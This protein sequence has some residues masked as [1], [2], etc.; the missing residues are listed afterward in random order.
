[1]TC[2]FSTQKKQF[3]LEIHWI[4][5][6]LWKPY[7]SIV[8]PHSSYKAVGNSMFYISDSSSNYSSQ[9]VWSPHQVINLTTSRIK[10]KVI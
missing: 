2:K 7:R 10:Q 4:V 8:L 5:D 9:T 1:M 6:F 3:Y